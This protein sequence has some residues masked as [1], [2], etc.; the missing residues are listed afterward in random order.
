MKL[1]LED[2]PA[3]DI[4]ERTKKKSKE[5][6]LRDLLDLNGPGIK[7]KVI[8]NKAAKRPSHKRQHS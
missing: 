5:K 8:V 6:Q 4:E 2:D 7:P 1:L 3:L